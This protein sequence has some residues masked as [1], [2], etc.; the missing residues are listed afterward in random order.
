MAAE[1]VAPGRLTL[2]FRLDRTFDPVVVELS[3]RGD[4]VSGVFVGSDDERAVAA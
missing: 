3:Q 2:A 4:A 1:G